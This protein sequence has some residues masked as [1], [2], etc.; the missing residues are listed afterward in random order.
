MREHCDQVHGGEVPF[1]SK[2]IRV[3][4]DPLKRQ[5]EEAYRIRNESGVSLNDKN[6]WMRPAGVR[7]LAEAM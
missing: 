3:F 2:V 7:V 1:A 5:L 4:K 6:E